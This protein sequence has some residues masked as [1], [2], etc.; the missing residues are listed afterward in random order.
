MITRKEYLDG[1][2]THRQYYT[3]FVNDNVKL[4]VLDKIGLDMIIN[5]KDEHFNDIPITIWDNIGL[6]CGIGNLLKSAGDF[7]TL[8]GQVAI[9]KESAK[10]IKEKQGGKKCIV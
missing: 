7:Y 8:A 5:S 4:M 6:P 10:Q 3:Q 9:L 1:K 2:Y